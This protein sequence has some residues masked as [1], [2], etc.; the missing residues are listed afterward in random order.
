LKK[1]FIKIK[2]KMEVKKFTKEDLLKL[3]ENLNVYSLLDYDSNEQLIE[4][5]KYC[6]E[7]RNCKYKDKKGLF[8]YFVGRKLQRKILDKYAFIFKEGATAFKYAYIASRKLDYTFIKGFDQIITTF[9]DDPLIIKFK[10]VV[11]ILKIIPLHK[12]NYVYMTFKDFA[13][14]INNLTAEDTLVLLYTDED[15]NKYPDKC[16]FYTSER[17]K[18]HIDLRE[19]IAKEARFNL[20]TEEETWRLYNFP[21]LKAKLL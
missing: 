17:I 6:N 7:K 20:L 16:N 14:K 12:Y 11:D 4:K 21:F 15:F 19:F 9:V 2:A 8:L 3:A 13:R 10:Q 1:K 5:Y 18:P